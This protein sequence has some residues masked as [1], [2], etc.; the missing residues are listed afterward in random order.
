MGMEKLF[1]LQ[2]FYGG[3]KIV[4]AD[5][6]GSLVLPPEADGVASLRPWQIAIYEQ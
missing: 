3:S 5:R 6:R 2:S 4:I 1:S